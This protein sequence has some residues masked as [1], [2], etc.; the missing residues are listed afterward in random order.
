MVATPYVVI[1]TLL[2]CNRLLRDLTGY[3]HFRDTHPLIKNHR[4]LLQNI[5]SFIGLFCKRDI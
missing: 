5:V 3:H 1:K 4:S 2:T